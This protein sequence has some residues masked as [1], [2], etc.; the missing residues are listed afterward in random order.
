MM[1]I[2]IG[3][4]S[5]RLAAAS[6]WHFRKSV[7][8]VRANWRGRNPSFEGIY[9]SFDE[10]SA[11]MIVAEDDQV[12]AAIQG[13]NESRRLQPRLG[14]LHH[15]HGRGAL[16]Q[17]VAMLGVDGRKIRI[18]DFGGAAGADFNNLLISNGAHANVD[19]RVIDFPAVCLAA[20]KLWPNENRISFSPEL[21]PDD[22]LFDIVYSWGSVQ[23]A[24]DPI[25]LLTSFSRHQPSAILI[26]GTGFSDRGFVR[27][28]INQTFPFPHW[29][30]EMGKTE[31]AMLA[32][33]YR[34]ACRQ[35]VGADYNVDNFDDAHQVPDYASL[36]FVRS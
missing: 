19:Y 9:S 20:Q 11:T 7:T 4:L 5:R 27:K 3:K 12:R 22:H 18:L 8:A 36:L 31:S 35:A 34:L 2:N 16:S 30:M 28:Q 14:M 25:A 21:P 29:V 1:G 10:F 15:K 6:P 23:Y 26:V 33:G 32:V 24:P 17:I 13:L